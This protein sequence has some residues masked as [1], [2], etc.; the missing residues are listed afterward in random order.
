M[1]KRCPFCGAKAEIEEKKSGWSIKC[2]KCKCSVP[3]CKTKEDA[4][5]AWNHRSDVSYNLNPEVVINFAEENGW[6]KS[7]KSNKYAYYVHD[8]FSDKLK[9][10]YTYGAP[11][12]EEDMEKAIEVIADMM[13]EYPE[14]LIEQMGDDKFYCDGCLNYKNGKCL[15]ERKCFFDDPEDAVPR[16]LRTEYKEM[17]LGNLLFGNSRGN[18]SIDRDSIQ[19]IFWKYFEDSFDYHMFYEGEDKTKETDRGGY[20][21]DVFKVNPYY[22]GD[23]ENI[24]EEPNFVY[25]PDGTEISW[26]KYPMRDAYSNVLITKE[27]AEKIF[28]E[29]KKS[30]EE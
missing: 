27:L 28:S 25:K 18:Y 9:I 11:N 6:T 13:Y 20:E 16:S 22:C 12:F 1:I 19:D 23:D 21:N 5:S 15:S 10:P 29:C 14:S 17:E 3:K 8:D 26:Y 30:M 2:P 4:I 24:M 7:S